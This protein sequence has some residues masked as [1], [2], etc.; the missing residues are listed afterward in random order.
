MKS[1]VIWYLFKKICM[2]VHCRSL[3]IF[4]CTFY[5]IPKSNAQ[6][7]RIE[8]SIK[9]SKTNQ[10]S[11][12]YYNNGK[13]DSAILYAEYAKYLALKEFGSFHS[14]YATSLNNLAF[15]YE[16]NRSYATAESM[17]KEV[18]VIRKKI[19]GE[20]HPEYAAILNNLGVIFNKMGQYEKEM[21]NYKICLKILG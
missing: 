6:N 5:F 8:D 2:K 1:P 15:L 18:L 19:F 16:S 21:E 3:L 17:Y 11:F 4:V 20:N 14:N 10:L 12:S 13:I 7:Y 9:W